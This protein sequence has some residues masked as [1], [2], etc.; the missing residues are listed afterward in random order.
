MNNIPEAGSVWRHRNGCEY[1]VIHLANFYSSDV[2]YPLSVVYQG[3]SNGKIWSRPMDQ[4][5][6]SMNLVSE[7]AKPAAGEP[8]AWRYQTCSGGRW[9]VTTN[10]ASARL[11]DGTADGGRVQE[12]FAVA[13]AAAAHGET[14]QYR[15]LRVGEIIQ[16]TDELLRDDCTTWQ[17]MSDGPQ[18]GIGY[19]WHAGLV[20]VRRVEPVMRVEGGQA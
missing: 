16:A 17:P 10:E 15:L 9:F 20:P 2:R 14:V 3:M 11:F 12:L 8:V 13:P 5:H 4:W 7:P 6:R 19:E 18:L 1:R